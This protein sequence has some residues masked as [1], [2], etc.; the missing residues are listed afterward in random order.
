MPADVINREI[1][2]WKSD[3]STSVR[4]KYSGTMPSGAGTVIEMFP[5]TAW[6]GM[7][8]FVHGGRGGSSACHVTLVACPRSR[9]HK[10]S[11]TEGPCFILQHG[12]CTV[13]RC[14]CR[15]D[16]A[17]LSGPVVGSKGDDRH[18]SALSGI[19]TPRAEGTGGN[20][21]GLGSQNN[22]SDGTRN[23]STLRVGNAGTGSS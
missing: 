7:M 5:L 18:G 16:Y 13:I 14:R 1:G 19:T 9:S 23:S 3:Q 12:Y 15:Q 6:K 8:V 11:T 20:C 22:G 2:V 17:D 4:D 10:R 21:N